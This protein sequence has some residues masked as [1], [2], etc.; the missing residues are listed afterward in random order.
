MLAKYVHSQLCWKFDANYEKNI[1]LQSLIIT[2]TIPKKNVKNIQED[3]QNQFS[4]SYNA[5]H[6]PTRKV[7]QPKIIIFHK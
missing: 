3:C 2:I 6:S 4:G 7:T 1:Y 5:F